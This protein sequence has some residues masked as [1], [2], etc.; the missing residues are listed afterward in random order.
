MANIMGKLGQSIGCVVLAGI[1]GV[2]F[3]PQGAGN[4]APNAWVKVATNSQAKLDYYIDRATLK[5]ESG[6]SYFWLYINSSAGQPLGSTNKKI[7][8]HGIAVYISADCQQAN[9]RMRSAELINQ[10]G[11]QIDQENR[12]DF[13]PLSQFNQQHPVGRSVL[14]YVC[15]R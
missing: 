9:F 1:T 8:V 7:P 2:V 11:Q 5:K 10:Q 13:G 4:A 12:G 14:N 3:V 15:N 6:F